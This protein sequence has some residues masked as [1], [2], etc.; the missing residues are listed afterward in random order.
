[1]GKSGAILMILKVDLTICCQQSCFLVCCQNNSVDKTGQRKNN[2][3]D[4]LLTTSLTLIFNNYIYLYICQQSQQNI[5]KFIRIRIKGYLVNI[6]PL[7]LNYE[8]VR[9]TALTLCTSLPTQINARFEL[10]KFIEKH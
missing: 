1:M 8:L 4:A 2:I 5:N 7:N 10:V 6:Y 3:V 9:E